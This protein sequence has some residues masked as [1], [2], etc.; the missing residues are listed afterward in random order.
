MSAAATIRCRRF[1]ELA[2]R[3]TDAAAA[4][5]TLVADDV[6]LAV[7][8]SIACADAGAPRRQGF[9]RT[10]SCLARVRRAEPGARQAAVCGTACRVEQFRPLLKACAATGHGASILIRGEAG[11]GKS[12]LVGEWRHLAADAGYACHTAQVLDFGAGS[13]RDAVRAL[14]ISLLDSPGAYRRTRDTSRRPH[15]RRAPA[16]SRCRWRG[17]L[18]QRSSRR[19]SADRDAPPL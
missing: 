12:R 10:G 6:K 18:P 15:C 19:R 4:G 17:R 1:G 16:P 3:L 8:G 5:E 2:S 14:L 13:A 7:A 11:I 9:R